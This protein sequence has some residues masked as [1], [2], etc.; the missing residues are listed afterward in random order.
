M[1]LAWQV[2]ESVEVALVGQNLLH[3]HHLEFPTAVNGEVERSVYG[4]VALRY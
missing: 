1:R 3:D 4:R 2:L